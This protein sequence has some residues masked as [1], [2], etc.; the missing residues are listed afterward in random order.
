M[1]RVA[2]RQRVGRVDAPGVDAAVEIDARV[3]RLAVDVAAGHAV[4]ERVDA[5]D[6]AIGIEIAELGRLREA[7]AAAVEGAARR[8]LVAAAGRRVDAASTCPEHAGVVLR[9]VAC[10]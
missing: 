10:G 1:P 9:G 7:D 4:A 8:E 5:G 6:A 3:E 2:E